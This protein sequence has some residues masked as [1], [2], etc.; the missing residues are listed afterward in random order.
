MMMVDVGLNDQVKFFNSS[1]HV[2]NMLDAAFG[3]VTVRF[4]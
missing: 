2:V 3:H 4:F 1:S